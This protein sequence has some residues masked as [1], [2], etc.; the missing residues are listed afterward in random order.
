MFLN[1]MNTIVNCKGTSLQKKTKRLSWLI[2]W[3]HLESEVKILYVCG[4]KG[5]HITDSV[6]FSELF[7]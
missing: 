2:K 4:E 7:C 3:Q 5:A 1:E 6:Y